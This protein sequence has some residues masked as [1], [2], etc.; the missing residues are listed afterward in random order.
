[1]TFSR[2]TGAGVLQ[3]QGAQQ[4]HQPRRG[5]GLRRRGAGGHPHR[6]GLLPGPGPTGAVERTEGRPA[7]VVERC[8]DVWKVDVLFSM[9]HFIEFSP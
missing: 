1:M 3:R 9:M 2:P 7:A 8:G 5:G 4:V 6:R